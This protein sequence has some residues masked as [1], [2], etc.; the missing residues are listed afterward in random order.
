MNTENEIQALKERNIRVE[1]DKAW[2]TSFTRRIFICAITYIVASAWL[3][4]IGEKG[5]WLKAVV[6]VAGYI[7]STISIPQIRKI[8]SKK[9]GS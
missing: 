6:P 1:L 5:I 9:Y 2:E 8:W 7:L 3:Y 4:I